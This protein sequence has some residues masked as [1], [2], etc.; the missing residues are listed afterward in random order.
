MARS[1][2][3]FPEEVCL[4]TSV[5][6]FDGWFSRNSEAF[7]LFD[8]S[9]KSQNRR[10]NY[11]ITFNALTTFWFDELVKI[12]FSVIDSD[13]FGSLY[14]AFGDDPDFFAYDIRVGIRA[15]GMIDISR[16]IFSAAAVNCL[17]GIKRK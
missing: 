14:F 12:A 2:L 3:I 4:S 8:S 6:D 11:R 13:L 10:F 15:A 9:G 5:S 7:Q 17:L 1:K 16:Q